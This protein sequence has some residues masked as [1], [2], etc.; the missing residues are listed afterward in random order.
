MMIVRVIEY[1]QKHLKKVI[2]ICLAVMALLVIGDFLFVD[3][4][5]A[6]T[7]VEH[8]FGFWSWFG[9]GSCVLIILGSKWYGHRGI[10]RDEDFYD[11]A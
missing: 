9:L 6:H 2:W 3:K 5:H 4:E 8:W 10:M 7:S 1:L 11:D